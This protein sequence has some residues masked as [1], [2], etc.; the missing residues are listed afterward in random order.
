L[1]AIRDRLSHQILPIDQFPLFE[2]CATQLDD[3][4]FRLHISV[5]GLCVDGWSA[6][7]LLQDLVKFYQN[8]NVTLPSLELS[9]RDYVLAEI[10]F[11]D[12]PTFQRSL[13]YWQKR[14]P[15][16]PPAP[17]LPLAKAPGS[18]TQPQFKC[19]DTK[20]E[21]EVWQPLKLRAAK[22][23]LTPTG[24]LLAAYAEVLALW[25]KSPRFTINVPRFNRLPLHPQVNDIIG[26]FA[27]FTL[28][29]VD[30]S[31]QESFE[32]RA[33]RLQEQLWKDLEHQ[34][35]SGVR[36]LRELSKVQG[37]TS[38]A[39]APVVFTTTPQSVGSH[40]DSSRASLFKELG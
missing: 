19:W 34:Y 9:F 33:R 29:E 3:H 4:H 26:E 20:L 21:P 6:Q 37:R 2:I 7:V 13:D 23:G 10:A 31:G 12:S 27:S 28:L 17:D 25:S 40:L 38:G 32:V 22:A 5:D 1:E 35:V 11:Q 14:L 15:T 30:N 8:P 18:L 39:I 16:L 24:I 36:V